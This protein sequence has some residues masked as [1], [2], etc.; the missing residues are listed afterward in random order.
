ML[1][2]TDTLRAEHATT[3]Q[4]VRI[5]AAIAAHVQAG[6]VFPTADVAEVLRFLREF[7][8]G[9]HLRKESEILYP[10]VAMHGDEHTAAVV[11]DL[12][13]LQD[14]VSALLHTLILFWEPVGDLT[15]AERQG[16]VDT[17]ATF[18]ARVARMQ[19]IEERELF[20]A[21]DRTVPADDQID[22]QAR[23]ADLERG[24]PPLAAWR[25]RLAPLAARWAA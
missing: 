25:E 16:F 12:V 21:C 3:A 9:V 5:L 17:A 8:L 6:A 1:R 19:A 7:L 23:F 22:W 4:G 20:S 24:R 10:L 13:R 11:G 14:E 18:T 2:P 15:S